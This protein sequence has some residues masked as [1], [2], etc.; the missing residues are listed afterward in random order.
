LP[1]EVLWFPRWR[2]FLMIGQTRSHFEI[3]E[4][5]GERR[6]FKRTSLP[7]RRTMFL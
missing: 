6:Y 3:L 7:F 2:A 5:P 1:A 4:K